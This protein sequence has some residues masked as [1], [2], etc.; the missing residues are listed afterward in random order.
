MIRWPLIADFAIIL[1]VL[2]YCI[3]W[4]WVVLTSRSGSW[5]V[6]GDALITG[7]LWPVLVALWLLERIRGR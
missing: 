7:I 4:I 2:G 1:Y 6:S 5:R 3:T